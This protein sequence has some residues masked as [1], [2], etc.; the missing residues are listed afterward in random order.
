MP[1]FDTRG[2]RDSSEANTLRI[3]LICGGILSFV[4]VAIPVGLLLYSSSGLAAGTVT[5][6]EWRLG[7]TGYCVAPQQGYTAL[8]S[9]SVFHRQLPREYDARMPRDTT[10]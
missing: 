5:C 1:N 7:K 3:L 2:P 4:L 9:S 6:E 10:G 8:V